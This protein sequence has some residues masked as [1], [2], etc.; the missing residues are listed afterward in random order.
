MSEMLRC[1]TVRAEGEES[2]FPT[3]VAVNEKGQI[4]VADHEL[5]LL[6]IYNTKGHLEEIVQHRSLR[7]VF[8]I[9]CTRGG[10]LVVSDPQAGEKQFIS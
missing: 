3:G 2:P 8:D 5:M 6:K 1:F 10:R 4:I 7:S 9:T